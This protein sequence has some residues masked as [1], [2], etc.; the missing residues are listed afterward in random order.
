MTHVPFF[1]PSKDQNMIFTNFDIELPANYKSSN[2]F[3]VLPSD[4]KEIKV[5]EII[6]ITFSAHFHEMSEIEQQTNIFPEI[7]IFISAFFLLISFFI[8]SYYRKHFSRGDSIA[9]S[10]VWIRSKVHTDIALLA[11]SG[12][13]IVFTLII[14]TKLIGNSEVSNTL[15]YTSL[16]ISMV[17]ISILRLVFSIPFGENFESADVF[18]A[19]LLIYTVSI[20]PQRF[21]QASTLLFG[22]FRGPNVLSTIL[23]D[24]TFLF[25]SLVFAHCLCKSYRRIVKAEPVKQSAIPKE[26]IRTGSPS[27][28]LTY[29]MSFL[30]SVIMFPAINDIISSSYNN[31]FP[32][33][34]LI[35]ASAIMYVT[36]VSIPAIKRMANCVILSCPF[37]VPAN[38]AEGAWTTLFCF[39]FTIFSVYLN[40]AYQSFAAILNI[41]CI[42]VALMLSIFCIGLFG[43][44]SFS[45]LF[46]ATTF[47]YPNY[48]V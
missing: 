18:S 28:F 47:Q 42:V 39:I 43:S 29:L 10:E 7:L 44:L 6:T 15:I 35:S 41:G 11:S 34:F 24:S 9:P 20:A 12:G 45:F 2:N 22:C 27:T 40:G 23:G 37:W 14:F 31:V 17:V 48:K 21:L 46:A 8:A 16:F 3:S 4:L 36:A 32:N 38:M 25:F 30:A 5:G 13:V 26:S 33:Y 1:S 19:V